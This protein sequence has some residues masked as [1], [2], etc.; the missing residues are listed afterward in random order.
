MAKAKRRLEAKAADMVAGLR[1]ELSKP[2][3]GRFYGAHQASSPGE[4][5]AAIT[6]ALRDS[7]RYRWLTADTIR[8]SVGTKYA[9]WLE[10]G[11]RDLAPRP[12]FRSVIARQ[13]QGGH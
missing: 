9:K 5:P 7:A 8:V 4:P 11:T 13:R 6:G 1:S 12:F 10:F 3:S 2:G